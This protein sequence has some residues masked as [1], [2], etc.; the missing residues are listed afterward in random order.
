MQTKP[1]IVLE[2]DFPELVSRIQGDAKIPASKKRQKIN[3]INGPVMF[4]KPKIEVPGFCTAVRAV[5]VQEDAGKI[6]VFYPCFALEFG[7]GGM[8]LVIIN[9]KNVPGKYILEHPD[10]IVSKNRYEP[11]VL[12][13]GM[14]KPG[15]LT[16]TATPESRQRCIEK[17]RTYCAARGR[18]LRGDDPTKKTDSRPLGDKIVSLFPEA[19]IIK[20]KS[21]QYL[22]IFVHKDGLLH[23]F[24]ADRGGKLQ[25]GVELDTVTM[26]APWDLLGLKPEDYFTLQ[27]GEQPAADVPAPENARKGGKKTSPT[28]RERLLRLNPFRRAAL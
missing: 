7:D 3:L 15:I 18:A 25:H 10:A 12:P 26:A 13:E 2:K 6:S 21:G 9:M 1:H 27:R 23:T 19:E 28:L 22:R 5:F 8:P 14:N 16:E 4:P 17:W 11:S 24:K 20:D